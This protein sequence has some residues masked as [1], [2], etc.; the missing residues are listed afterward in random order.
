MIGTIYVLSMS[1]LVQAKGLARKMTQGKLQVIAK[2][3]ASDP[4]VEYAHAVKIMQPSYLPND[5]N[6]RDVD[7]HD[8][9]NAS[10]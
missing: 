7:V 5:G 6:G 10:L 2:K 9:G 8:P 4:S 1:V 3:I